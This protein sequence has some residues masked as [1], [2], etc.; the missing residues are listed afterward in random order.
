VNIWVRY[1]RSRI[2][3]AAAVAILLAAA[4][5]GCS[6]SKPA[7]CSDATNLQNSVKSL[8]VSGGISALQSQVTMIQAN[9]TTLVNSAKSDFPNET[10][11]IT[12]S[13]DALKNSVT[14]L[15]S[16]RT[17]ANIATVTKDAA[18]VGNSV[19]SFNDATSSQCG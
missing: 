5:A 9:A 13:V 18:N 7:Y 2:P 16:D 19:K 17:A 6:S 4:V 12:S 10:S 11:A 8:N 15:A 3:S 1:R 14:A